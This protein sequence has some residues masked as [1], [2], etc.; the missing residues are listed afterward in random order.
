MVC[1]GHDI[2]KKGVGGT[3]PCQIRNHNQCA[4]RDQ[5]TVQPGNELMQAIPL[6]E[7]IERS[8]SQLLVARQILLYQVAVKREETFIVLRL[9]FVDDDS[10]HCL[11]H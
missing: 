7:L 8:A 10:V 9:S 11:C 1:V 4:G 2:F 3:A 6:Y 5:F